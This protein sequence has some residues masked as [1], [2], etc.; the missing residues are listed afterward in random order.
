MSIPREVPARLESIAI[1][2]ILLL[3][4]AAAITFSPAIGGSFLLD[5]Q[6]VL[7]DPAFTTPSGVFDLL[8][9]SRVRPLTNL[10]L[11]ANYQIH[12]P[13]PLGFHV[14]NLLLHLVAVWFACDALGR[15][16][17]PSAALL[18][19]TVFALHP[20]QAEPVS[21]IFAR[22]TLLCGLFSWAAIGAWARNLPWLAVGCAALAMFSKEEAIALPVFLAGLHLTFSRD[23]QERAPL[24]AMFLIA[25]MVGLRGLAATAQVAGAGAGLGVATTPLDYALSQGLVIARYARLLVLPVGLNFD[26]DLAIDSWTAASAWCAIVALFLY[27]LR[28]SPRAAFWYGSALVF[29]AP[30]STF[31]PIADV[32]ADRRMYLAGACLAAGVGLLLPA[33]KTGQVV[34]IGLVLAAL[35]FSRAS[36]FAHPESLWRD[37]VAGSPAKARPRIQLARVVAPAEAIRLLADLPADQVASERGRAYLELGR[38]AEALREFG[39][40]LA[41]NP[42][43]PRALVNRGTALAALN[44]VAAAQQDFA[45]ALAGEP[46][47][48]AA[49]LNLRRLGGPVPAIEKCRFT[50]EQIAALR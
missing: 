13:S 1:R 20:L 11:W 31:L 36:L 24:G 50:E 38:P 2:S 32:S 34:A 12:G 45:R 39:V 33:L 42:G 10:T 43:D 4:L 19:V 17:P 29:L 21:Y 30:T 26:P 28:T 5:D 23:P 40:A 7:A 25:L 44:Q 27:L 47:L 15:L 8:H 16:L 35:S 18:A 49:L 3:L 41:R 46:C 14:V 37:T 6:S 22:T 9:P 48:Y